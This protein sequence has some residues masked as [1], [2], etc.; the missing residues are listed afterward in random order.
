VVSG[1]RMSNQKPKAI[2]DQL[3]F[4][5]WWHQCQQRVQDWQPRS[6]GVLLGMCI[7]VGVVLRLWAQTLPGNWDFNQWVNVSSAALNG[8]DPYSQFG[9]N[10]PPPWL[11]LTAGLQALADDSDSFRLL[12]SLVLCAADIGIALILAKRGYTLAACLYILSPIA[13]AISGQHQQ[14]ESIALVFA[15]AAALLLS[16]RSNAPLRGIDWWAA[17]L[18]GVSLAFKPVF[19]LFPLWLLLR[20]GP[21]RRRL[22]LFFVSCAVLGLSVLS[23]F[24]AYPPAEV[25]ARI[26][27]HQGTDNAPFINAF[28]PSQL[29]PWVV[30]AGGPKIAF[31]VILI[32]A[33]FLFRKLDVFEMALAYTITAVLFSWAVANQ[34]LLTPMAGVAVYL[35]IGF[36]VWLMLSTIYLGG[37]PDILNLWGLKA[38]QQHVGVDP[39][40]PGLVSMVLRRVDSHARRGAP[41]PATID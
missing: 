21:L 18:L 10:Y 19:L 12:I 28:V 22:M 35:N 20:S 23:A 31:I 11:L 40:F 8:E 16:G 34:Y 37:A 5:S 39:R 4:F 27:G 24:I 36:F 38:I 33:A 29:A 41:A 13:I 2:I 25:V 7:A 30:D 6:R 9:Y 3:V 14:V 26:F 15:F 1:E 32:A 17:I